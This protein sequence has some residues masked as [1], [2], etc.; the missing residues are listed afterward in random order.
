VVARVPHDDAPVTAFDAGVVFED[1]DKLP[2]RRSSNAGD[3]AEAHGDFD[4]DTTS[5]SKTQDLD[6][7]R[8]LQQDMV[9]ADQER[10]LKLESR[11]T[12]K[13]LHPLQV[14]ITPHPDTNASIKYTLNRVESHTHQLP[15]P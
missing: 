2:G 9:A 6:G 1:D 15:V 7:V 4:I 10:K 5:A 12:T 11:Y 8:R 14:L 3:D 13:R